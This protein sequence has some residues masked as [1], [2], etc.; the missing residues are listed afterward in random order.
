MLLGAGLGGCKPPP[1]A[2][3]PRRRRLPPG[4]RVW[5]PQLDDAHTVRHHGFLNETR[6]EARSTNGGADLSLTYPFMDGDSHDWIA[7]GLRLLGYR[8]QAPAASPVGAASVQ[9]AAFR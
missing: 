5:Q 2:A 3:A 8:P 9:P 4:R 6:L 1:R 7:N